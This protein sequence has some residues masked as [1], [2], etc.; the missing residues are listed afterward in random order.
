MSNTSFSL[1][2]SRRPRAASSGVKLVSCIDEFA[3]LMKMLPLKSLPP[4]RGTKLMRTPPVGC[5]ASTAAMS[6]VTS[7]IAVMLGAVLA[8][9]PARSMVAIDTPFIVW[10]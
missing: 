5:V 2:G 1:P 8:A 9:C 4:S 7:C 6:I 3:P 10:R